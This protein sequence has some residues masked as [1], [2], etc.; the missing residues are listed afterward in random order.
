MYDYNGI[1]LIH[2]LKQYYS[3]EMSITLLTNNSPLD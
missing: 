1:G 2:E 3:T